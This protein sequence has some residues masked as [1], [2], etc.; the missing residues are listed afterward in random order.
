MPR[1][2]SANPPGSTAPTPPSRHS[3]RWSAGSAGTRRAGNQGMRRHPQPGTARRV[4]R[5]RPR[6]SNSARG[7]ELR[8]GA[9][10]SAT[11]RAAPNCEKTPAAQQLGARRRIARKR[12]QL[13]NSAHGAELRENA[14]SSAT[15]RT[16]PNCEKA[17]AAQQLGAQRRVARKKDPREQVFEPLGGYGIRTPEDGDAGCSAPQ[18]APWIDALARAPSPHSP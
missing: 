6:L 5:R 14:R 10:G 8:E 16:A 9:R 3:E 11:R 7:A 15:R 18:F 12:P 1:A 13:S 4:A 17:P 2:S